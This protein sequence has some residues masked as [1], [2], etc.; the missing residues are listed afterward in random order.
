MLGFALT[1]IGL[2]QVPDV[3]I[4]SFCR[5]S[6]PS[7]S[8][9]SFALQF[10]MIREAGSCGSRRTYRYEGICVWR[11]YSSNLRGPRTGDCQHP[12]NIGSGAVFPECLKWKLS[13]MNLCD[14]TH[15]SYR[16]LFWPHITLHLVTS[17]VNS[18][19]HKI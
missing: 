7:D 4:V 16:C 19:F 17:P 8:E 11:N 1:A 9:T 12:N 6:H 15:S 2:L 10:I 5:V 3:I 18:N 14:S 13:K